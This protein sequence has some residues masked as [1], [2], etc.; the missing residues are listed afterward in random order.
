M[1]MPKSAG[2]WISLIFKIMGVAVAA[3]P[4][5][6]SVKSN[7]STPE[8]IPQG[9]LYTYTGYNTQT[10]T[11]EMGQAGVGIGSIVGGVVLVKVGSALGRWVR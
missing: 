7:L 3:G 11:W 4:G 1:R 5:L 10:Q 2:G 8:L 9:L 6:I